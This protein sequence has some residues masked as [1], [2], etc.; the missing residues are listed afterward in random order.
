M[1]STTND[2]SQLPISSGDSQLAQQLEGLSLDDEKVDYLSTLPNE[3]IRRFFTLAYAEN[4]GPRLPLNKRLL[5][6]QYEHLFDAVAVHLAG[7]MSSFIDAV[8]SNS[9]LSG[10]VRK[11]TVC[12]N[13]D[14]GHC[15]P[16]GQRTGLKTFYRLCGK[17]QNLRELVVDHADNLALLV[18]KITDP[19]DAFLHRMSALRFSLVV[20]RLPSSIHPSLPPP[21]P[22]EASHFAKLTYLSLTGPKL[23]KN[24][25][26]AIL[27][28]SASLRELVLTQHTSDLDLPSLLHRLPNPRQLTNLE[29]SGAT[30]DE[31][32]ARTDLV[33]ALSP[34]TG[35]THLRLLGP[36]DTELPYFYAFLKMLPLVKLDIGPDMP[37]SAPSILSL[38][39]PSTRHPSLKTLAL[40][41]IVAVR[42][43]ST[44]LEDW[45]D[46]YFD[47]VTG[48]PKI[49][50]G[51]R[52]PV[53]PE[54]W[55]AA[56]VRQILDA[57][58]LAGVD[59]EG[60]TFDAGAIE[61]EYEGERIKVDRY[62]AMEE[63]EDYEYGYGDS[64]SSNAYSL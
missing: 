22:A 43:V 12:G 29:L 21:K 4:S 30:S 35:L 52:P 37:L 15:S 5:P 26:F 32:S 48:E 59:T 53:W 11:L 6:F 28:A 49:P 40:S 16:N 42:G 38:L 58:M 13:D 17:L 31:P 45:E 14:K 56:I 41:N 51:W 44:D 62:L 1:T 7:C 60:T 19:E 27:H 2:S 8:T 47:E 39:D 9:Q 55:T 54:G 25:A 24:A 64:D 10:Y 34:F 20:D 33:Q 61:E 57:S 3:L 50:P 23:D 36:Y 63:E 18:L 46:V